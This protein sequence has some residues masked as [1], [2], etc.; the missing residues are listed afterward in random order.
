MHREATGKQT[1][2][3]S[4]DLRHSSMADNKLTGGR[5]GLGREY[6][7]ADGVLKSGN[8]II[9][10]GQEKG[11][12]ED[13]GLAQAS[14]HV[15]M[16]SVGGLP[17]HGGIGGRAAGE[18]FRRFT[19]VPAKIV[20]H[21][22]QSADLMKKLGALREQDVTQEAAHTR[23]SLPLQT[24]EIS[25]IERGGVGNGAVVIGMLAQSAQ[26]CRKVIRKPRTQGGGNAHRLEASRQTSCMAQ[27]YGF[28]ERDAQHGVTGFQLLDVQFEHFGFFFGQP[29]VPVL[30]DRPAAGC[31]GAESVSHWILPGGSSGEYN[32]IVFTR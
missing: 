11:F 13:D 29:R 31:G 1:F 12:Q 28:V 14:I 22:L 9:R 21:F 27:F 24:V 2:L 6:L 20:D 30:F 16:V 15:E 26:Q 32:K 3:F 19:V 7:A 4:R 25:R 8:L 23:G 10:Q 17:E 5:F 18:V